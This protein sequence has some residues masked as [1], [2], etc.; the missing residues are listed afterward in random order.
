MSIIYAVL[1]GI[2]QGVTE[3]LPIS[4]DGHLSVFGHFFGGAQQDPLMFTVLLHLGTLLAVIITYRKRLASITAE[5]AA[6]VRDIFTGRFSWKN[7]GEERRFLIMALISLLPLALLYFV[8]DYM[9]YAA[10]D[11]NLWVEAASFAFS[12]VMMLTAARAAKK[13]PAAKDIT[14]AGALVVGFFQGLA[15]LPGISRSGSTVAAALMLGYDREKAVDFSFIIG[16]PAILAANAFKILTCFA[17]GSGMG[18]EIMLPMLAGIAV[19]A[20]VGIFAIRLLKLLVKKDKFGLF[21]IYCIAMGA[22]CA[23]VSAAESFAL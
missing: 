3:F 1:Q 6:I 2:L 16:I 9:E 19:S 13:N 14:V 10:S 18:G 5:A 12:G 21:G 23:A 22:F 11:G 17:S 20:V 7:M 4:S 8:S 15:A